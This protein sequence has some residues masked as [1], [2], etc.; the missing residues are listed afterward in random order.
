[1]ERRYFSAAFSYTKKYNCNTVFKLQFVDQECQLIKLCYRKGKVMRRFKRI[2]CI[3]IL[4]V[5]LSSTIFGNCQQAQTVHASAVPLVD[6]LVYLMQAV[7]S[8]Q[9]RSCG[10]VGDLS[11][12]T[13]AFMAYLEAAKEGDIEGILNANAAY[14]HAIAVKALAPGADIRITDVLPLVNVMRKF[15]NMYLPLMA[16]PHG[17]TASPSGTY[18]DINDAVHTFSPLDFVPPVENYPMD[19]NDRKRFLQY[20][21][22]YGFIVMKPDNPDDYTNYNEYAC[23]ILIYGL[24]KDSPYYLQYDG[25]TVGYYKKQ[26]GSAGLG[27]K[28]FGYCFLQQYVGSDSLYANRFFTGISDT[29]RHYF[30]API[31]K[32]SFTNELKVPIY[33]SHKDFLRQNELL[34]EYPMSRD[35]YGDVSKCFDLPEKITVKPLTQTQQVEQIITENPDADADAINAQVADMISKIFQQEQDIE[36]SVEDNTDAV[37]TSNTWL[38]KIFD[39]LNKALNV[40]ISGILTV[41]EAIG[42]DVKDVGKAIDNLGENILDG[43]KPIDLLLRGFEELSSFLQK[44]LTGISA[45]VQAIPDVLAKIRENVL[46]LPGISDVLE[47]IRTV[48][49]GIPKAITDALDIVGLRDLI[50]TLPVS[51]AEEIEKI[52]TLDEAVVDEAVEDLTDVWELKLPF[53]P[54]IANG[55]ENIAF[56]KELKY[57]VFKIQ[58]PSVIKEFLKKDY[59]ILFDGADYSQYFSVFRGI[60]RS[61]IWIWFAWSVLNHFK[62]KFHVG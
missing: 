10:S 48:V 22:D 42:V 55:F 2:I 29:D 6:G 54:A 7:L 58:C 28:S 49:I 61:I 57:P 16:K 3:T 40:P 44:V 8:S 38:G 1:M 4:S 35:I 23:Y 9:G 50:I 62:I 31:G 19:A 13:D 41:C 18:K 45:N 53:I 11:N 36:D 5:I 39:T 43:L 30:S 15:I 56:S 47:K 27:L 17:T 24:P 34:N 20:C 32:V 52:T 14:V 37:V 60:L 33:N 26:D 51:I 46:T 12:L 59:I 25:K 21:N